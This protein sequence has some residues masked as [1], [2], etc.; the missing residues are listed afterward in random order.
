MMLINVI[1]LFVLFFS[2]DINVSKYFSFGV[3]TIKDLLH[4]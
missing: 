4:G 3:V 1:K 2:F